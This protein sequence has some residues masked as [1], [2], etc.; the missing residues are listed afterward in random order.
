MISIEEMLQG[1]LDILGNMFGFVVIV[2]IRYNSEQLSIRGP[3]RLIFTPFEQKNQLS[4]KHCNLIS[5]LS[6]QKINI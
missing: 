2:H 4:E 1:L 3:S 6:R 5:V